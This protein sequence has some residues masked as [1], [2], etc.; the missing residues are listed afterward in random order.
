[1]SKQPYIPFYVG[2][3]LKDTRMLPL[4]VRGA[5]VDLILFMWDAPDRGEL[6]GTI[7]EFSRI[8]SCDPKEAEF[9]LNLL[10]Q[11]KTADIDLLDNGIWRI[12]SRRMKKD[13]DISQKRSIA[14]KTGISVKFAKAKQQTKI[15]QNTDN[16]IDNE[17]INNKSEKFLKVWAEWQRY[18][19]EIHKPIT[20]TTA[21]KQLKKLSAYPEAMAIQ[22]IEQSMEN[23]WH[24]LFD[25][26][27]NGNK[28]S[29]QLFVKS[30]K[31]GTNN[32]EILDEIERIKKSQAQ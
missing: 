1:M 18:R 3:Y 28:A 22:I 19:K 12:I 31:Q 27:K 21:A 17:Y 24:G 20:K 4:N 30:V 8:M 11:K 2:D 25:V 10:K 16:D 5:W 29:P 26:V 15:K 9:A 23:G 14:G 7:D 13:H 32:Q 6:T